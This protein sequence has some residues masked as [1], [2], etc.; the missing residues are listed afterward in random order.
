MKERTVS[1]DDFTRAE[2]EQA[3]R[4]WESYRDG[5]V[6]EYEDGLEQDREDWIDSWLADRADLAAEDN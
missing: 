3:E 1:V 5:K 4:A 2:V 6:E